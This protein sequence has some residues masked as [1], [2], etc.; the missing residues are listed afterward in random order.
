MTIV[1]TARLTL[2][3]MSLDDASFIV[4]LLN[5]ADFLR[6]IG[7]KGVRS[8]DDARGYITNGAL[9]SYERHGFGLYVVELKDSRTPIGICGF[10]KRDTLPDC[11][12]GYALLPQYRGR[13]YVVEAAAAAME[14][15]RHVLA[16]PRVL[17]ITDPD[18]VRSIRVLE[19]IGLRYQRE[20]PGTAPGQTLQLFA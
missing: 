8:L 16:I 9:A 6:Y 20:I 4:E 15:G 19:K 2:R 12:V 11:D 3:R 7:D 10:V 5:D 17:G 14:Y 13:G 18:N 1:D